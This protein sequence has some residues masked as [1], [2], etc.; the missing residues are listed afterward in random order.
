LHGVHLAH[1]N[2]VGHGLGGEQVDVARH[3]AAAFQ[4]VVAAPG[5]RARIGLRHGG[6]HLRLRA[7]H[8][9]GGN[10]RLRHARGALVQAAPFLLQVGAPVQLGR[11]QAHGEGARLAQG[12][13]DGGLGQQR[14]RDAARD[15][16]LHGLH[17][18]GHVA[19][20]EVAQ[21]VQPLLG[22]QQLQ[23]D[24][25]HV[26][27]EGHGDFLALE[28]SQRLALRVARDD[29]QRA[30]GGDVEQRDPAPRLNRLAATLLGMA[31]TSALPPMAIMRSWSGSRQAVNTVRC[32]TPCRALVSAM[33][34]SGAETMAGGPASVICGSG[35][36]TPSAGAAARGA[37]SRPAPGGARAGSV[38]GNQE[39]IIVHGRRAPRPSR[40]GAGEARAARA[41]RKIKNQNL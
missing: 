23:H 41:H 13:R 26:A 38:G 40:P 21:R 14:V 32:A 11:N 1:G 19:D 29:P 25:G 37:A 15:E 22:G 5:K 17:G 3:H 28:V 2:G 30:P 9:H 39:R 34:I 10:A 35:A 27:P 31:S 33:W 6:Q 8:A 4:G 12:Q 36:A 24:V 20:A 7:H 18:R 16:Q